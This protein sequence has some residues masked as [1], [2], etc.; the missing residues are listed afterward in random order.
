[1]SQD[2]LDEREF[3]LINIVGAELSSNQRDLSRHMDLSLGMTN[4]LIRRLIS[5]GYIG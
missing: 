2:T 4:I 1:M 5:K 3:E